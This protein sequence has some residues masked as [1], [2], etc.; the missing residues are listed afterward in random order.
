M[1]KHLS[2]KNEESPLQSQNQSAEAAA[3]SDRIVPQEE[4]TRANSNPAETGAAEHVEGGSANPP[5]ED[6]LH[7]AL[8]ATDTIAFELEQTLTGLID[9]T[10][11]FDVPAIDFGDADTT[12]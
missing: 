1:T 10:D 4:Q 3:G 5:G 11:L 6:D 12:S 7:S 8:V 2:P 9:S